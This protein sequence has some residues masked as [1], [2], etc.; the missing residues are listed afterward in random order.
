MTALYTD[1][2]VDTY[3]YNVELFNI[4]AVF[5]YHSSKFQPNVD[6]SFVNPIVV[7][8][9]FVNSNI[10]GNSDIQKR[11]IRWPCNRTIQTASKT[12]NYRPC[13]VV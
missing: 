10:F 13:N 6:L 4:H 1:T 11:H 2:Y 7:P 12:Q 3:Y 8:Y 5:M 9:F